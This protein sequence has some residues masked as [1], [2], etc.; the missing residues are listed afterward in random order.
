[1]RLIT[2]K[3]AVEVRVISS[4]RQSRPRGRVGTSLY[5][6]IMTLS[7]HRQG[8]LRMYP[9][10]RQQCIIPLSN[11]LSHS[12]TLLPMQILTV[13]HVPVYSIV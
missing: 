7:T 12:L 8:P 13:Q 10:S 3:Y 2:A 4:L 11:P 9:Q 6:L 1:M 5:D